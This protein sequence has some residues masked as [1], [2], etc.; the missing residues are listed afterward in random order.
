MYW[1]DGSPVSK[2]RSGQPLQ[3]LPLS[4]HSIT[5]TKERHFDKANLQER[6]RRGRMK[7]GGQELAKMKS[8]ISQVENILADMKEW[9]SNREHTD[10]SRGSVYSKQTRHPRSDGER[11][12]ATLRVK[13]KKNAFFGH[14]AQQKG[15]A[16]KDTNDLDEGKEKRINSCARKDKAEFNLYIKECFMS[17]MKDKPWTG[18]VPPGIPRNPSANIHQ[19]KLIAPLN[20]NPVYDPINFLTPL[21]PSEVKDLESK[22]KVEEDRID[23]LA[24]TVSRRRTSL[25]KVQLPESMSKSINDFL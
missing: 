6:K 13:F 18:K 2:G 8:Y 1:G 14:S 15:Q 7:E 24:Y 3:I 19:K 23:S 4:P 25:R 20:I 22:V 11:S 9:V 21:K 12:K 10:S 16:E 17:K 5:R